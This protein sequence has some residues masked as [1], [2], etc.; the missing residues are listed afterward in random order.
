MNASTERVLYYHADA[1]P[2]GGYLTHPYEAP[3][4]SQASVSLSQAG[5]HAAA[6]SESFHLDNLVRVGP[7][8]SQVAGSVQKKTGNWTTLVTSVVEDLNVLEVVT[9]DRIVSRIAIEHPR[10]DGE[11]YPK[12]VFVGTQFENL[13]IAGR[14]VKPEIDLNLLSAPEPDHSQRSVM[15]GDILPPEYA[16]RGIEF[17]DRPWNE[18]GAFVHRAVDQAERI[19]GNKGAP[20]WL[21]RR[22]EWMLSA[23]ARAKKGYVLSS[24]VNDVPGAAP[25]SSFGHIVHVPGFGNIFLGELIV[26]QASFGLTMLRIEMG[27]LAEGDLSFSTTHGNGL[28]M[29]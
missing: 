29:P 26:D 1:S 8:Y 5:G 21:K 10:A 27:C 3:I 28:P 17:P 14:S 15:E 24:L 22:Y 13:R 12:V 7:H 4:Q 20:A 16:P 19:V 2:I 11:Y 9:A 18:V 25:G 23:E 6:R